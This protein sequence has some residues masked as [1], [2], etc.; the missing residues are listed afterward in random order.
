M[1]SVPVRRRLR[2]HTLAWARDKRSGL[3]RYILELNEHERGRACGCACISCG[4]PLI[5]VNAAKV[6]YDVRPHFRHEGGTETQSCQVLSA[7]AALLA[8]LQEGGLIVLP[9]S[10]HCVTVKG[11]SG[12]AY[13]GWSEIPAQTVRVASLHYVDTTTADI[14]LDDGRRLRVIVIGSATHARVGVEAT[15]LPHIEICIDDP[16]LSALSPNELIARLV[17]AFDTGSWCGHWPED[18]ASADAQARY[19][20]QKLADQA[21]DWNAE[22]ED[23]H[24]DLRRESL[25][26][27][28]VKS[29]LAQATS[30]LLPGWRQTSS[31]ALLTDRS[32]N[33]RVALEGARLEKKLG[34]IIPDVIAKLKIGGELLVEVTVTNT[35]TPERLSRIRAVNMPTIEIDFSRMAGALSRASLR[36][37]VLN[38]VSGKLWL[39]HPTAFSGTPGAEGIILELGPPRT[40]ASTVSRKSILATPAEFWAQ[41]YLGAVRELARL[42]HEVEQDE[43]WDPTVQRQEALEAVLSAADCLH[44]HGYPEALDH[45]L[46]D[47][48]RT[49][50]HRVMSIMMG[51]PVAYRYSK[52]WQVVNSMLIDALPEAM[53][54]HGL[55]LLAIQTRTEHLDFTGKQRERLAE[56]QTAVRTSLRAR[57]D[58]YRR[59][60]RHDQLFA[61]L[62]PDLAVGLNN[63]LMKKHADNPASLPAGI[64]PVEIEQRFF[65]EPDFERW[66][67]TSTAATRMY[68]LEVAASLARLDNRS[69]DETS[70]LHQILRH[71]HSTSYVLVLAKIVAATL[72]V[73][74]RVVLEFLC[75]HG[76]IVLKI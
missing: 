30:V 34:R 72:E 59:R 42:D 24:A 32:L 19:E 10:R 3:L 71:S 46:F 14:L 18:V 58:T 65:S 69:V 21:L 56:W 73:A 31:G 64:D 38:D 55:Y 11:L 9:R 27:R 39:H 1:R 7:R 62:F 70:I 25:L 51:T 26:H 2:E 48:Q 67:W 60:P 36:D 4:K 16:S 23:L 74:P 22:D 15:L 5:S 35:I 40:G 33:D 29:I 52:V 20:A 12:T 45:H 54:W 44:L 68:A 61:L 66:R 37:L 8:S 28:E 41:E 49:T 17:P 6:E 76:Y 13:E 53:S 63:A 47:G 50:L 43:L 75:R 57:E